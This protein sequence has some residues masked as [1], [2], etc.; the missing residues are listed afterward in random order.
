MSFWLL[1]ILGL[2]IAGVAL[3]QPLLRRREATPEAARGLAIYRDQ[4]AEIERDREAGLVSE[5]EAEAARTEIERRILRASEEPATTPAGDGTARVFLAGLVLGA[6]PAGA[7]ALYLAVGM[8]SAP[9]L[10]PAF[11]DMAEDGATADQLAEMARAQLGQD[12]VAEAAQTLTRATAKAPHRADLRSLL[13]EAQ[14]ALADGKVSDAARQSFRAAVN[15]DARDPRA[16]FYLGLARVQDGDLKGAIEDWLALEADSPP[17]APWRPLLAERL[18]QAAAEAGVDLG[19]RRAQAA[20]DPGPRRADSAP[21]GPTAADVAAAQQLAPADR[22]QMIRSMVEGLAQRLEDNPGDVEG[23]Q[24]LARARRVLGEEA[25]ATEA[26]RRASEAAPGR[27]DVQL[28]YARALHPPGSPPEAITPG[29]IDLMRRILALDPNNP[30]GLF[31][32]GEAEARAGNAAEARA[33]WGRLLARVDPKEQLYKMIDERLK[34][35]PR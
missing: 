8:P 16:R 4:L 11:V 25:A 34:A 19:Q 26:L 17:D 35:L 32:V 5:A 14:V 18:Q 30:E 29:F 33:L 2:A 9:G 22:Q 24:R 3:V 1:V 28:D 12:R 10:A 15:L 21:R 27:L 20:T 31:F 23:W 7:L 6:V 13:G